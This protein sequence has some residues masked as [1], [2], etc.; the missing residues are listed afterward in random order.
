M[1]PNLVTLCLMS[2]W[3]EYFGRRF[4]TLLGLSVHLLVMAACTVLTVFV[5]NDVCGYDP[6]TLQCASDSW[7]GARQKLVF[8]LVAVGAA[9]VGGACALVQGGV[10]G[11]SSRIGPRFTQAVMGGQAMAGLIVCA[12]RA[13]T[14]AAAPPSGASALAEFAALQRSRCVNN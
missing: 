9:L 2:R 12:C 11:L 4:W 5:S 13:L 1:V 6:K 10:F 3:P 8:F 14:K 7:V